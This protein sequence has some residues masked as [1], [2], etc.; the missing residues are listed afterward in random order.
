M[1][2]C[3]RCRL[4]KPESEFY[5]NRMNASGAAT[6]SSLCKICFGINQKELRAKAKERGLCRE[7]C[8]RPIHAKSRAFCVE[9]LSQ[10]RAY[11]ENLKAS[12]MCIQGCG[13]KIGKHSRQY[14]DPCHHKHAMIGIKYRFG[15]TEVE[16]LA[17]E[18]KHGGR[19]WIC[20][21]HE[22]MTV[23]RHGVATLKRLSVD[24]CHETGRVRG[25]LCNLCN[26]GIGFFKNSPRS[27]RAAIKYIE[28]TAV[29]TGGFT[30][31][32]DKVAG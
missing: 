12:G 24:H 7:G 23:V 2:P 3:K 22:T 5:F 18:A 1:K 30:S 17:L 10:R 21:E 25:L 29:V 8:G 11:Q 13:I 14:C 20:R 27:L 32:C 28:Q 15:L 19:C 4:N 16:Y 9:H 26:A 31:T 6:F